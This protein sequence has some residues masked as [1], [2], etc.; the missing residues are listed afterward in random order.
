[1]SYGC[2]NRRPLQ[3]HLLVQDG[4]RYVAGSDGATTRVPVMK[5]ASVPMTKDC[6]HDSKT[7]TRCV[8]CKWRA[9]A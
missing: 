9:A 6:Q 1:M 2:H 4:W 8:G 7:D 3:S 5:R